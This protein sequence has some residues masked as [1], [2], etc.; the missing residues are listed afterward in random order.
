MAT[1]VSA[2]QPGPVMCGTESVAYGTQPGTFSPSTQAVHCMNSPNAIEADEQFQ[3]IVVHQENFEQ[4][5][6]IPTFSTKRVQLEFP[7]MGGSAANSP[8]RFNPFLQCSGLKGSVVAGTPGGY[9]WVLATRT[10]QATLAATIAQEMFGETTGWVEEV[11]GVYGSAT[12]TAAPETGV[13]GSLTGQ[14]LFQGP[15]SGTLKS[16]Y[17]G[18]S[19]DWSAGTNNANKAIVSSDN[20]FK[21]NNGGSDYFPICGGFRF[22]MGVQYG[23]ITDINA[24]GTYGVFGIRIS[25][26]APTLTA[27]LLFDGDTSANVDYADLYADS[28]AVTHHQINYTYTDLAGRTLAFDWE[29]QVKPK[30]KG[31]RENQRSLE[32]TYK[33]LDLT[34]TQG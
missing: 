24:G 11:N 17:G 14:G 16:I 12:I 22:D 29:C 19:T 21:I 25:A 6:D 15:Q 34:I 9:Q 28:Q 3:E 2:V 20:R 7:L 23:P 18:G 4:T 33:I 5:A 13:I 32:I 1:Q 8:P 31:V 26:I 27:T 30:R 10:Q